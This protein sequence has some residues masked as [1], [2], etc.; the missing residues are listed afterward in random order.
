ME[1]GRWRSAPSPAGSA[2]TAAANP[3]AQVKGGGRGSVLTD[4]HMGGDA[5]DRDWRRF[6]DW[7]FC[8]D[9]T[10]TIAFLHCSTFS[11]LS[12]CRAQAVTSEIHPV[13][14][15]RRRRRWRPAAAQNI[16]V[17][18]PANPATRLR[19]PEN[20][21]SDLVN[22]WFYITIKRSKHPRSIL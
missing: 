4:T 3:A 1:H 16:T 8:C 14:A 11:R 2:K 10:K 21:A 18:L 6:G 5:L 22:Y 9:P 17:M 19:P 13:Q 20:R 7:G 12:D 15:I